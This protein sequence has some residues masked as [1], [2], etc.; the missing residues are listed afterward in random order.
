MKHSQCALFLLLSL[1]NSRQITAAANGKPSRAGQKPQK[2]RGLRDVSIK[3]DQV[4]HTDGAWLDDVSMCGC[5]DCSAVALTIMAGEKT[6]MEHILRYMFD[7]NT[8]TE[9]DEAC[10]QVANVDFPKACGPGCDPARCDGRQDIKHSVHTK[11]A[12]KN[13]PHSFCGCEDCT[14]VRGASIAA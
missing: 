3:T 2:R 5:N 14:I 1:T 13:A 12:S 11:T 10:V 6:C 8:A 7:D 9:E 4:D